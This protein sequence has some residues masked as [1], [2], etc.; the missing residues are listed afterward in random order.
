MA[1]PLPNTSDHGMNLLIQQMNVSHHGWLWWL[2]NWEVH[3]WWQ[4]KCST[5]CQLNFLLKFGF[6]TRV[7]A[8]REGIIESQNHIMKNVSVGRSINWYKSSMIENLAKAFKMLLCCVYI[9][10][11]LLTYSWFTIL[12][13]F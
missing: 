1:A 9:K 6:I 13:K 5:W 11:F 12:Y 7:L 4:G 10:V 2:L 8:F 3:A